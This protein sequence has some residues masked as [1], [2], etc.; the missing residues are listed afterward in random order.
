MTHL[1]LTH[2][3][4]TLPHFG[5]QCLPGLMKNSVSLTNLIRLKMKRKRK[6][7]GNRRSFEL[8]GYSNSS[9]YSWSGGSPWS[10]GYNSYTGSGYQYPL[11]YQGHHQYQEHHHYPQYYGQQVS[12]SSPLV[13]VWL[14]PFQNA[15]YQSP[16]FQFQSQQRR[17]NR[18]DNRRFRNRYHP[19]HYQY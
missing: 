19:Y 13:S 9:Q 15:Y 5:P 4:L 17:F 10:S 8:G 6:R 14:N 16:G 7:S 11:Q 1:T 12:P 2:L 3:T 18:R